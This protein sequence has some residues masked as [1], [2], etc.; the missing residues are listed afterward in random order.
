MENTLT[1]GLGGAHRGHML[2]EGRA[3]SPPDGLMDLWAC[4]S[5]GDAQFSDCVETGQSE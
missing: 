5:V 4:F 1:Q 3:E 2:V